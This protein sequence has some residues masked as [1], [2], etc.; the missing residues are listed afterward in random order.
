MQTTNK[1]LM[2]SVFSGTFYELPEFD[3]DKMDIGQLPLKKKPSSNCSKCYGRGYIGKDLQTC[4]YLLCSC[5]RKVID[6]NIINKNH[7]NQI[8]IS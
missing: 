4:G 6:Y 8:S 3:V 1:T 7:G 2:F 5:M